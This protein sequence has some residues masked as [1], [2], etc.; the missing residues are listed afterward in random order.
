MIDTLMIGVLAV[1]GAFSEHSKTLMKLGISSVEIRQKADLDENK[2]DG[3]I[4][5]GGEST[6]QA[7]LLCDL[8]IKDH[9][10]LLIEQEVPV[11][12]TCAGMILLSQE[13]ADQ[14][15]GCLGTIPMT[16]RRNG[17]GRQLES[18]HI[19]AEFK[20]AG[21]IPMTFIRAPYVEH[22]EPSVEIL[23]TVDNHIVAVRYHNQFALA[24]H[25]E[26]DNSDVVLRL[27]LAAVQA[28]KNTPHH[29]LLLAP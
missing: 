21:K 22:I 17:Y 5:P 14:G 15:P 12:A 9:L 27:F 3:L 16:V 28:H 19:T 26:L 4:L 13:I 25:P 11:L 10:R 29:D 1:Q 7:K 8:G 18:F 6:A 24:F 20:G 23:S 2:F